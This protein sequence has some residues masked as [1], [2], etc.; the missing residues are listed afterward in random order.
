M[1]STGTSHSI[2]T[3][4]QTLRGSRCLQGQAAPAEFYV[5]A[6]WDGTAFSGLLIDRRPALMGQP[7]LQYLIPVSVSGSRIT[8]TVPAAL[9]A[10]VQ[11]AVVLPG[12]TWNCLTLRA[13]GPMGSIGIHSADEIGRQ[14]WPQ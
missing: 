5:G 8:L 1:Y 2:L 10:Q 4:R 14:P 9:A 7:A 13:D 11:A 6:L 3:I 12:A